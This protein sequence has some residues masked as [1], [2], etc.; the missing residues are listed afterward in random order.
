MK[1]IRHE[2]YE[3]NSSSTHSVSICVEKNK[4]GIYDTIIPSDTGIIELTGGNF[5]SELTVWLK[6]IDKANYCVAY[7]EQLKENMLEEQYDEEEDSEDNTPKIKKKDYVYIY[8]DMLK[9]VV[10]EHT[11]A[12]EVIINPKKYSGIAEPSNEY[13][14]YIDEKSKHYNPFKSEKALKELIFNRYSYVV[15]CYDGGGRD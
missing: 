15:S 14:D 2:V 5:S 11:G 9:S 8:T 7:I 6:P 3:T 4:D 1:Q 12:K 10:A 13:G